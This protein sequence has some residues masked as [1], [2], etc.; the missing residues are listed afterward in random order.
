MAENGAKAEE[1]VQVNGERTED[2]QKLVDHGIDPKVAEEL[3]DI[4]KEGLPVKCLVIGN[5]CSNTSVLGTYYIQRSC[6]V[7]FVIMHTW[8]LSVNTKN[9]NF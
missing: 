3:D 2:Y 5:K 7:F 8:Q 1:E 9:N 4:Y 6:F